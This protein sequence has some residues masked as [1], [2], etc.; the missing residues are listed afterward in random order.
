MNFPRKNGQ[1]VKG[2]RKSKLEEDHEYFAD[3][4]AFSLGSP[5]KETTI[6]DL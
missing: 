4:L 5:R 1:P 2:N 3:E 6:T